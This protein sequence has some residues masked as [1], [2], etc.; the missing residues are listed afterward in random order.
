M[1]DVDQT[2]PLE[3]LLAS[4]IHTSKKGDGLTFLENE[5]QDAKK[6]L[7]DERVRVWDEGHGTPCEQWVVEGMCQQFHPNP[8]RKEAS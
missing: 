2:T 5:Y 7:N 6:L 3:E 4:A 8:Y 1:N